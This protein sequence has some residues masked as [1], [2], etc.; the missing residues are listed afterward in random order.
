MV[1]QFI[2]YIYELFLDDFLGCTHLLSE[3]L[4]RPLLT[5]HAECQAKQ[6]VPP[7]VLHLHQQI[8]FVV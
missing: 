2:D 6:V 7:S 1:T 3:I 4:N 5:S 8:L